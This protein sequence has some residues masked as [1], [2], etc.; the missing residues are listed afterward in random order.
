M[1]AAV[2]RVYARLVSTPGPLDTPCLVWQ[3]HRTRKGYG[4]SWRNPDD[5]PGSRFTHRI[6]WEAVNGPVP[7]GLRLRHRCAV[8]ACANPD[9]LTLG[10][11]ADN[12]RDIV[13]DGNARLAVSDVRAALIRQAWQAGRT[14]PELARAFNLSPGHVRR[15]VEGQT[16]RLYRR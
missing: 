16:R 12:N 3:G 1:A 15:I 6:T 7:D 8:R 10:T 9:H 13:E 2:D 4:V 14:V 5:P 11:T